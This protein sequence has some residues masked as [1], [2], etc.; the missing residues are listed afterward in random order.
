MGKRRI[1]QMTMVAVPATTSTVV[2]G[3]SLN[4]VAICF[5]AVISTANVVQAAVINTRPI[6]A[7]GDGLAN[8]S[9]I[10]DKRFDIETWGDIVRQAWYCRSPNAAF[11]PV[12]EVFEV[13]D[14]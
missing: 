10:G 5:G 1:S 11:I 13:E 7:A 14:V 6:A 12:I 9:V 3:T 2:A 4:R 8:Q